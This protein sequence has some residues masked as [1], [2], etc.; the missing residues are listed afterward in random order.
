MHVLILNATS[1]TL[2]FK[3]W[4]RIFQMNQREADFLNLVPTMIICIKRHLP[5]YTKDTSRKKPGNYLN[6]SLYTDTNRDYFFISCLKFYLCFRWKN[7]LVLIKNGS[8]HWGKWKQ[9]NQSFQRTHKAKR[10]TWPSPLLPFL[11]TGLW[12]PDVDGT[13]SLLMLCRRRSQKCRNRDK[14]R[15][16]QSLNTLAAKGQSLELQ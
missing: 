11:H 8:F 14:G 4:V 5:W 3:L 1:Y 9:G 10:G 7:L 6:I 12:D 13:I 2:F 16:I 15:N